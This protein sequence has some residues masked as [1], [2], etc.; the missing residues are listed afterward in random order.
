HDVG[1]VEFHADFNLALEA[2][3]KLLG[4]LVGADDL[5]GDGILRAGVFYGNGF[6]HDGHAPRAKEFLDMVIGQ[7][8]AY[9]AIG[10]GGWGVVWHLFWSLGPGRFPEDGDGEGGESEQDR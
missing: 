3:T 9:H 8:S 10:W 7:L 5:N 6:V 1:V 2:L 4:N